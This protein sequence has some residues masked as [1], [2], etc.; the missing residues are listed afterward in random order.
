MRHASIRDLKAIYR[1]F[2]THTLCPSRTTCPPIA[3]LISRWDQSMKKKTKP[4]PHCP[5]PG[6][7]A[8]APH[9]SDPVVAALT[10]NFSDLAKIAEWTC[11][12][13][14]ELGRSMADDIAAGRCFALITRTRQVEELYIRALYAMF[15]AD[16]GDLAHIMSDATPNSF[17][18]MYRKVNQ[19]IFGGKGLLEVSQP[20]L[21]SGAFSAMGTINSGAHASFSTMMMVI[22]LMKNPQYHAALTDGRYFDHISVYCSY[23]DHARKQF[24]AGKDKAS[25]LAE[26]IE[27][28][29]PKNL[30]VSMA[31]VAADRLKNKVA[32]VPNEQTSSQ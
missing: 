24:S 11:T 20:G 2:H 5:V 8:K 1:H 4:N 9:L 27:L 15:L 26:L 6:C 10:Q 21:S 7:K 29:L 13:I 12:S 30:T 32:A 14:A 31:K 3:V 28:H 22:G 18:E 19:S 23:L 17:S 16:S 25:V